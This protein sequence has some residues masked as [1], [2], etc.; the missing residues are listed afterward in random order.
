MLLATLVAARSGSPDLVGKKYAKNLSG[1]DFNA[2]ETFQSGIAQIR[3]RNVVKKMYLTGQDSGFSADRMRSW[4]SDKVDLNLWGSTNFN[5][6]LAAMKERTI[7]VAAT[8]PPTLIT[9]ALKVRFIHK[10]KL[11][12]LQ[13]SVDN[14][15]SEPD[16]WCTKLVEINREKPSN[17]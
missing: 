2:K 14:W 7:E 15:D 6:L 11:S 1:M 12:A 8:A 9:H 17:R 10:K 16:A 3:R 13:Y 5:I 4:L